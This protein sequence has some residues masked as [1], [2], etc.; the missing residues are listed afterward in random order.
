[1]VKFVTSR[2]API[3]P[4]REAALAASV[5]AVLAK[6][7]RGLII[8]GSGHLRQGG[9]P[10]TARHLIDKQDPG[11]FYYVENVA[12]ADSDIPIGSVIVEGENARLYIGNVEFETSVRVSPLIFRDSAYW[13]DINL[14]HRFLSKEWLDLAQPEFEYRGRYFEAPWPTFLKAILTY[15]PR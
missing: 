2:P 11:K 4:T 15:V 14:M 1:L 12:K 6:G 5:H 8:A 10:G 9:L 3:S 13:R 7:H